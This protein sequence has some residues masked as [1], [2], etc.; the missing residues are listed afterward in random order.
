MAPP[1]WTGKDIQAFF[2]W[3][4]ANHGLRLSRGHFPQPE[5]ATAAETGGWP[6]T[7]TSWAAAQPFVR[8]PH[9]NASV[10]RFKG[11]CSPGGGYLLT[12]PTAVAGP[13][14]CRGARRDA[15]MTAAAHP[16]GC[17]SHLACVPPGAVVG[18]AR[19]R[20]CVSS[21]G[22]V[23]PLVVGQDAPVDRVREAAF[24]AA[25]G[26]LGSLVFCELAPVVV[27]AWSGVD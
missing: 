11:A 7:I 13:G 2:G 19:E 1:R 3:S 16:S 5:D 25:S 23:D 12:S 9:C 8:C 24:E 26:F 10:A 4:P 17:G 6:D 22:A 15:L 14:C 20:L 18:V 21:G 27:T